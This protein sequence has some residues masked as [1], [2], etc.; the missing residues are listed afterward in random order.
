MHNNNWFEKARSYDMPLFLEQAYHMEVNKSK[1]CLCPFHDDTKPSMSLK[2]KGGEW[3]FTCFSCDASGDITKFVQMKENMSPLD[4][5]KKVLIFHG[6]N[7][8]VGEKKE[9]TPEELAEIEKRA[10]EAAQRKA[11]KIADEKKLQKSARVQMAK[12]SEHYAQN[13]YDAYE[14]GNEKIVKT[15]ETKFQNIYNNTEVR[16][17]YMGWD[18]ENDALC[19]INRNINGETFNIKSEKRKGFFKDWKFGATFKEYAFP[20]KWISWKHATA[21]AFGFDFM[22]ETDNRVVICEGEKDAINLLLL[23]INAL[24][25]GG[26]TTSW[27]EHKHLLMGK[28][29]FIWFD[30]DE[31]GYINAIKKYKE[32]SDVAKSCQVIFFYKLGTFA[33]KYDISDY[34]ADKKMVN[35]EHVFKSIIFSSFIPTNYVIFELEEY[36]DLDKESYVAKELAGLKEEEVLRD[37]NKCKSLITNAVKDV[38]GEKDEEVKLMQHLAKQLDSS[39]VKDDLQKLINSLFTED[40]SFLGSELA[41]LQKVIQFKKSMLTDYR[42][43]HIYDMVK[44]LE[45]ATQSAG[46]SFAVYRGVLYFWTGNYFYALEDWEIKSFIM[47]EYLS[48]AKIDFKKQTVKT[49]DEILLN[50]IGWSQNLEAWVENNKRVINMTNGALIIRTSGKYT[51]R[52]H[53]KK[54]DCAMNMLDFAYDE[55]ATAPKW[56]SF[57]NRVLPDQKDQDT[58]M[59]FIGYCLLP[60]HGY[61]SFLYLYGS[62]GANG[63][64][65]VLAVI[66]DFF[67][68]E[69]ISYL[70]LHNFEGHELET[71]R[72]KI[73]N[74]GSEIESGGDMRKQMSVLKNMTSAEDSLTVNPKNE[75]QFTI[76]PEEKPKMVFAANKLVKS[77]VD[78]GGV[79]R[80]MILLNF[81]QEIKDDEKIRDL[82]LRLRDEKP[83]ILN[84][85]IKGMV[86]LIKNNGFSMSESRDKFMEQYRADV[87]PVLAYIKDCLVEDSDYYIPKKFVYAH[88]QAWCEEKG[89][90]PY[91]SPTFWSK[92]KEQ[93]GDHE[94]HRPRK[95]EHDLLPDRP[96]CLPSF[97][98]NPDVVTTFEIGNVKLK[99]E[100]HNISKV[101]NTPLTV[102]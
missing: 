11:A 30:H 13:L 81:N 5:V 71:L 51:F 57:L 53:H 91:A 2:E 45:R 19:L 102:I 33:N 65:V 82:P 100:D 32:I 60:S 22:D 74:I 21:H 76:H 10:E 39:R 50:L 20:G 67:A 95:Y 99:T 72:N 4:A 58:L 96:R 43:T 15:I 36:L 62:S 84:M 69:N 25:L 27:E 77:G 54:Q 68:K 92:F 29:V 88:Y 63:K 40:S 38:R 17:L 85:A 42:Q 37:F 73:I 26:V 3:I 7:I 86:R 12:A 87:N 6:E 41:S 98:F 44:E 1:K 66:R 18:Y 94:D 31:A 16:D 8:E 90:K 59:E 83:G 80:R 97:K 35:K 70:Q 49:R 9:L 93:K 46:Y 23:G 61:E 55:K 14:H 89:H 56:K 75:K 47:K 64:S 78:D 52:N 101:T 48:A 79:Q 34:I 28:N 24:T